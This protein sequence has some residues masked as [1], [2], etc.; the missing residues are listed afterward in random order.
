[1]KTNPIFT[2]VFIFAFTLA[3]G[4]SQTLDYSWTKKAGGTYTES[5][6]SVATDASGNVIV[7]GTF[8]S[9]SITFGNITLTK[10]DSISAHM[11]IVKYN[12]KGDV[13]WARMA[14]LDE[15]YGNAVA[16][17]LNGN[18][19]VGGDLLGDSVNFDLLTVVLNQPYNNAAFLVKYSADGSA[20]WAKMGLGGRWVSGVALDTNGNLYFTGCFNNQINFDN[21][22]V[23][24]AG[25]CYGIFLTKYDSQGN[26]LWAKATNY[27]FSGA[28]APDA[29]SKSVCTDV[30]NNVYLTG[31][32]GSDSIK[33]DT[34]YLTNT[35]SVRNV[36]LTKYDNAGNVLWVKSAISTPG[37]FRLTGNAVK[38]FGNSVYLAGEFEGDSVRFGNNLITKSGAYSDMFLTKYDNLGNNIWAKRLGTESSDYGKGLVTDNTGNIYLAGITN[39]KFFQIDTVPIDTITG[40]NNAVIAKFN[41]NGN[42]ILFKTP[43]N[44]TTGQNSGQ[45]I[46]IDTDNNIFVTG[47]F[48]NTVSFGKDTLTSTSSWDDIFITKLNYTITNIDDGEPNFPNLKIFPNPSSDFIVIDLNENKNKAMG[49]N[50]YNMMGALIKSVM[51]NPNQTKINIG[52]LCNGIYI[53]TVKSNNIFIKQKFIVQK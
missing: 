9:S 15:T 36:F 18:I 31:F 13:L 39:G 47:S 40:G 30:D 8:F 4:Y 33:F 44:I 23:N 43:L 7:T 27:S 25:A 50:I 19:Y 14:A 17:D 3:N 34:Y 11:F 51:I 1:M 35:K 12:S 42:F 46:A 26:F 24:S 22:I 41:S 32:F 29:A 2:L 37:L 5:G 16:T 38:A 48:I 28:G 6:T 53:L 45:N 21:N 49:V 20:L 10:T 52:D